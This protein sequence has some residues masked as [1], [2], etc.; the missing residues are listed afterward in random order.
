M[1]LPLVTCEVAP[2]TVNCASAQ[3]NLI[4]TLLRAGV[5]VVNHSRHLSFSTKV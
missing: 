4:N 3:I 2:Q 5:H 1:R